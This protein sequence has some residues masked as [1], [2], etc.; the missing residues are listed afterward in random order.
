MGRGSLWGG[1]FLDESFIK[2]VKKK[3]PLGTWVSVS[4]SDEKKFLN[5]QWE[6]GIKPQ[7]DNQKRVWPVDLPKSCGNNF[8][9]GL[10]GGITIE[11]TS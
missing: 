9:I 5:D 8:S 4:D 10:T 3:S 1:V 7:F 2:L 11:L 6:H